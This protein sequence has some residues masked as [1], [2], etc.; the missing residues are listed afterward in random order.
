VDAV[1]D[2]GLRGVLAGLRLWSRTLPRTQCGGNLEKPPT[3][4]YYAPRKF[5]FGE[6]PANEH[7]LVKSFSNEGNSRS[8]GTLLFLGFVKE[9][10]RET[11]KSFHEQF[12]STANIPRRRR[13]KGCCNLNELPPNLA[14]RIK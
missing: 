4:L 10:T 12:L 13:S 1:R 2:D 11:S 6:A 7:E 14:L 9:A 8:T 3:G 5:G